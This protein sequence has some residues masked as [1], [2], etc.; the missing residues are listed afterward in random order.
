[1]KNNNEELLWRAI[2]IMKTFSLIDLQVAARGD[3]YLLEEEE[4]LPYLEFLYSAGFISK[5]K[6]NW[7]KLINK[8]GPA[9]PYKIDDLRAYDPNFNTY[10]F[11][12]NEK[13]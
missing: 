6:N 11:L 4:I 3:E 5:L 10:I 13:K 7:Y 2:R 8:S 12:D 1:M 9:S